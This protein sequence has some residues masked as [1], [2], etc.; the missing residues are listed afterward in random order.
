M[1]MT[2]GVDPA[3]S[4]DAELVAAVRAGDRAAFAAVYDRY[5]GR[6]YD[7]AYATTR[8]REDAADAVADTFVRFAE[9]LGQLRE[10][11]RLRPWLYA[12]TRHECLR[13]L[14]GRSRMLFD[15]EERLAE[16]ADD[17]GTPESSA[18]RDALRDLV[19]AAAAGL[20]DRDRAMLDLHLRQGLDGAELGEAMGMSAAHA[21]VQLNRLRNQVERSLGALLVARTGRE[22]CPELDALLVDWDGTLTPIIRKRVARH[23]ENCETCSARK[24][25]MVSPWALLA[26]VPIVLA[27]AGLRDRVLEEAWPI[28]AAASGGGAAAGS[29][30]TG[31]KV[32][33]VVSVIAT[34][35]A[36][37]LL[38][39][40]G[41][42]GFGAGPASTPTPTATPTVS[43]PSPGELALASEVLDLGVDGV[44]GSVEI[45][46]VG[47]SP[48]TVEV[49]PAVSWVTVE[50]PTLDLDPGESAQVVVHA[51]RSGLS[52]G[53]A[54]ATVDLVAA[55]GTWSFSVQ[56]TQPAP[57]Q[58]PQVA[59]PTVVRID[60]I[61][62]LRTATVRV[63][64]NAEVPLSS[65]V[66]SWSSDSGPSGSADMSPSGGVW[67]ATIGPFSGPVPL[68]VWVR[69][70]DQRGLAT[71]GP[72]TS[73]VLEPCS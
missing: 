63:T 32:L 71:T 9:R 12:I 58:P 13:R 10:P 73:T 21:Y 29:A 70:V 66:V 64:V 2:A 72:T 1:A 65:V 49:R 56:L 18:E 51:E 69:A 15:G 55:T 14:K 57:P 11:D 43:P 8:H 42:S 34:V 37:V 23:V 52:P 5:G 16:M 62:M 36:V 3:T 27:P 38:G 28:A 41:A 68:N 45:R 19:W 35:V 53:P 44:V 50:Q 67:E 46:N 25:R 17:S 54:V 31:V 59:A 40:A 24:R 47:E 6:L 60:C 61:G 33:A 4:S 7:F 48:L 20:A 26:T 39:I 22:E 30:P